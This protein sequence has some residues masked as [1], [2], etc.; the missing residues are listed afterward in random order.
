MEGSH[1][2][3]WTCQELADPCRCTFVVLCADCATVQRPLMTGIDCWLTRRDVGQVTAIDMLPDEILLAIFDYFVDEYAFRKRDIESWQSLVHVCRR[4]RGIVFGSP[5]RLDLRLVC[6]AK[7]PVREALDVWPPLPLVIRGGAFEPKGVNNILAAL[8]RSDRVCRIIVWDFYQ[9]SFKLKKVL[10][11]MQETFPELTDLVINVLDLFFDMATALPDSFLGGSAPRLQKLHLD[12]V[13]LPS[14]PKLLLTATDLVDLDL[15]DIPLSGY[16]SPEAMATALSMLTSLKLLTLKFKPFE[17][18]PGRASPYP[19]PTRSLLPVLDMLRFEGTTEYLDDLMARIDVPRLNTLDITFNEFIS[20]IPQFIQFISRTST[21]EVLE[22]VHVF[23]QDDDARI[24]LS[25][26]SSG[27]RE[28]IVKIPGEMQLL[29]ICTSYLPPLSRSE[30]LYMYENTCA[31]LD[32]L[33]ED[34]LWSWLW[35]E[36]LRPFTSV[37]NL[38]L[39]DAIA[40]CITHILQALHHRGRTTEVLPALENIFFEGI[41]PWKPIPEGIEKFI[42]ARQLSGRP[43]TFYPVSSWEKNMNMRN[44]DLG[45]DE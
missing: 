1:A 12:G 32:L 19:P 13:S 31:Q 30:N 10:A 42:S 16:I 35:L 3:C 15:S 8:E 27:Y 22:T 14:L 36:L 9:S 45:F 6:G 39:S 4:W 23:L 29:R 41:Q 25:S 7:T 28:L 18:R 11:A 26:E 33:D 21:L 40:S 17:S 37:K 34:T 20:D 38:Y 2:C 44:P 43:I 5:H 24:R